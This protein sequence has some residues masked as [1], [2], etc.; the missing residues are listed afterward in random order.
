VP[1]RSRIPEVPPPAW[2]GGAR[3]SS[4]E[5]GELHAAPAA[6]IAITANA[7]M[8]STEYWRT[9]PLIVPGASLLTG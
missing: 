7:A 6:A 5:R 9:A 4:P 3:L 1:D 8:W 2:R